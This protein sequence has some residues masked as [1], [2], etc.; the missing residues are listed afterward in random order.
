VERE[1]QLE[2]AILQQPEVWQLLAQ[3]APAITGPGGGM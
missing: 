2:A 3:E 1:A